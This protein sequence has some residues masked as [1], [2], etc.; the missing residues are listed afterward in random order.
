MTRAEVLH[1][2]PGLVTLG[3]LS[4]AAASAGC[5]SQDYGTV[6]ASPNGAAAPAEGVPSAKGGPVPRVPRGPGQAQALQEAA[7]K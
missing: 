5:S 6:A 2:L 7:K 4:V 3:I 1:A